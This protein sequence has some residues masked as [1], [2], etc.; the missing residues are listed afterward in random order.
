VIAPV[1][2]LS[3][4]VPGARWQA[5]APSV[6]MILFVGQ[7][8]RH[9]GIE[10][11]IEAFCRVAPRFPDA[12]LHIVGGAQWEYGANFQ[13]VLDSTGL[14]DRIRHW[15]YVNDVEPL[16]RSCYVF[17]HPSLPSIFHESF[18]RSTV[19]AMSVGAPVVCF[20]SGALGEIVQHQ[21]TGLICEEES[22]ECLAEALARLLADPAERNQYGQNCVRRY[23]ERYA[24]APILRQWWTLINQSG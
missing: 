13:Q 5:P 16:F 12:T 11:L 23:R 14:S 19:E 18:G 22:A 10:L 2:D 24:K 3:D 20:R 8:A 21:V 15:G 9:K 1:I 17:V 6:R 7:V 4:R